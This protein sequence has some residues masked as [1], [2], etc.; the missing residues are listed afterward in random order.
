MGPILGDVKQCKYMV[1]VRDFPLFRVIF[2]AFG[3]IMI[4]EGWVPR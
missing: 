1:I 3:N 2:W 4:F